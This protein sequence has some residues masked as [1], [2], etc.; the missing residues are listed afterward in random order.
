MNRKKNVLS[1]IGKLAIIVLLFIEIYPI[2]W[3]L[4][5]S[6]KGPNEFATN[7]MLALPK[8]FYFKNYLDAWNIGKMNIFFKNS[9]IS[10]FS[11]LIV[12][13][14]FS[15]PAAFAIE[16]MKWKLSKV[17][18]MLFL[19]GIMIPVQVVLIPLFLIY[20]QV[21][22][23]NS[24]W[25]LIITYSAFGLPLSIYLLTGYFK[26]IPNELMEAALIDGCS[27]YTM[28]YHIIVPLIKNALVIIIT[29]EFLFNWNDLIFSMTFISN[30]K[31]KTVQTGLMYFTGEKGQKEWGPIFASTVIGMVPTL[32]LYF[33]LNKVI[34]KG[35]TAGSVKG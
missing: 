27:I 34:I 14:C 21:G 10:V 16:K 1:I 9:V 4:L 7:S 30:L 26:S 24:L 28:F 17:A 12:I 8:G 19:S 5:S 15:V 32:L 35:M 3:L 2:I 11:A 29:V 18:L 13:I 25:S 31:L 6:L 22:L 33:G 23:L 20:K